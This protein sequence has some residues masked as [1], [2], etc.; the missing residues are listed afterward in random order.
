METYTVAYSCAN[1]FSEYLVY[2][3]KGIESAWKLDCPNCGNKNVLVKK[4]YA[5]L[6]TYPQVLVYDNGSIKKKEVKRWTL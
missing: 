1:C 5:E 4:R 3:Q 6:K 2:Y